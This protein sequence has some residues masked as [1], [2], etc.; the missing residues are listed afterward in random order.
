MIVLL[1][2][3]VVTLLV[4]AALGCAVAAAAWRRR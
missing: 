1:E 2:G 4:A 3:I